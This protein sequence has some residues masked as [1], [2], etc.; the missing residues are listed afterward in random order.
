MICA[1]PFEK[2]SS[3]EGIEGKEEES[4]SRSQS[5]E[6]PDNEYFGYLS[7]DWLFFF[8]F[9]WTGFFLEDYLICL[10][11]SG[12]LE[13]RRTGW[14]EFRWRSVS[15]RKWKWT[16]LTKKVKLK[17]CY[18][19]REKWLTEIKSGKLLLGKVKAKHWWRVQVKTLLLKVKVKLS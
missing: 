7:E 13:C 1:N 17:H 4:W 10:P 14:Q 12:S 11:S 15:S 16:T 18:H 6:M 8:V 9:G 2:R 5:T 3:T 19:G